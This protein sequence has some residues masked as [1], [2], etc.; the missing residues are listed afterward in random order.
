MSLT[1]LPL[2][3]WYQQLQVWE[4]ELQKFV[5]TCIIFRVYYK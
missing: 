4:L 2:A 3:D 5:V 1:D